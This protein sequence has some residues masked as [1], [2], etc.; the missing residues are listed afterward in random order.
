MSFPHWI[1]VRGVWLHWAAYIYFWY[2]DFCQPQDC[3]WQILDTRNW[4]ISSI[5][6]RLIQVPRGVLV[7]H[8]ENRW[9]IVQ[10][11]SHF[12]LAT[13]KTDGVDSPVICANV[14]VLITSLSDSWLHVNYVNARAH[15]ECQDKGSN[16]CTKAHTHESTHKA[17]YPPPWASPNVLRY[18]YPPL[19]PVDWFSCFIFCVYAMFDCSLLLSVLASTLEEMLIHKDDYYFS[20]NQWLLPYTLKGQCTFQPWVTVKAI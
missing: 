2:W 8:F 9:M 14:I 20:T 12:S 5:P 17:H 3:G 16:T 15:N 11:F 6:P 10:W 13:L 7:P 1:S 19:A 4:F 18:W